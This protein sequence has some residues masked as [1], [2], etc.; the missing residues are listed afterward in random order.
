MSFRDVV[1]KSILFGLG[2]AVLTKE[3]IE[4]FVKD[5]QKDKDLTP[6]EGKKVVKEVIAEA[7]KR[8]KKPNEAF[9]KSVESTVKDVMK[10]LGVATKKDLDALKKELGAKAGKAKKK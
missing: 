9:K 7:E 10:G 3:E 5:L 6:E 8:L 1:K 4:D 2:A